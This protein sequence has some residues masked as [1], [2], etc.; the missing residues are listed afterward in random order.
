MVTSV[1]RIRT[2]TGERVYF[3]G[4]DKGLTFLYVHKKYTTPKNKK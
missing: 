1:D 4:L 2:D 3:A